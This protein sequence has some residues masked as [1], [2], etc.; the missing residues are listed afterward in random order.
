MLKKMKDDISELDPLFQ[1]G[2]SL[3]WEGDFKSAFKFFDK[4]IKKYG[5]HYLKTFY[6][7]QAVLGQ[8]KLTES[9]SYFNEVL[10]QKQDF[11]EG[12][13]TLASVYRRLRNVVKA[14]EFYGYALKHNPSIDEK[15]EISRSRA[16]LFNELRS[17]NSKIEFLNKFEEGMWYYVNNRLHDAW[18]YFDEYI[19]DNPN[20]HLAYLYSAICHCHC[21]DFKRGLPHIDKY[22]EFKPN[23]AR[24]W[25]VKAHLFER[26][27]ELD[28]AIECCEKAMELDPK[29]EKIK[30]TCFGLYSSLREGH[31][32]TVR[33]EKKSPR[34]ERLTP[35]EVKSPDIR[36]EL[37]SREDESPFPP[38][39]GMALIFHNAKKCVADRDKRVH[40]IAEFLGRFKIDEYIM[41]Q[42]D[43]MS[44]YYLITHQIKP[45]EA[46]NEIV[47]LAAKLIHFTIKD[48]VAFDIYNEALGH[49]KASRFK[50]AIELLNKATELSPYNPMYMLDLY[51]TYQKVGDHKRANELQNKIQ[52]KLRSMES[53]EYAKK[54]FEALKLRFEDKKGEFSNI[55][56]KYNELIDDKKGIIPLLHILTS[57]IVAYSKIEEHR[58]KDRNI[59]T[60][61]DDCL[62]CFE[63]MS[64]IASLVFFHHR[65]QVE[66]KP[67]TIQI[68]DSIIQI[69][70]WE[71]EPLP[72]IQTPN[73][74]S[75]KLRKKAWFNTLGLDV[76]SGRM[77]DSISEARYVHMGGDL[78]N[79]DPNTHMW[80]AK[81]IADQMSIGRQHSIH[82]R[83]EIKKIGEYIEA[84]FGEP[85]TIIHDK[86]GQIVHIDIYVYAPTEERPF[87]MMIT[88]GM[89]ECP[90]NAPPD[91]WK[92]CWP[93]NPNLIPP[94]KREALNCKYA[95]LVVK[96]PP[97]WPLPQPGGQLKN[98]EYLWPIEQLHHLI[99]YVHR[100]HEWF[101]NGHTM[102]GENDN[103]LTFAPNTKLAGW[104]FIYPPNFPPTFGM[105]KI[106]DSKVICFLQ[107]VPAYT[108]EIQ[109]SM[110]YGTKKLIE[111]F[112]KENIPDFIDIK[113]KNICL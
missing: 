36:K 104:V 9:I 42:I 80:Q 84:Q 48:P 94:E 100:E 74:L 40:D 4:S 28:R 111:K 59:T 39:F 112:R 93:I 102:G 49:L 58:L 54:E 46:V 7:G 18:V 23:D 21:R 87:G 8:G 96:L 29:S 105:L 62:Y 68:K 64:L 26:Q 77:M 13:I 67:F 113:R 110:Q 66:D 101:W 1:K 44:L 55:I 20:D 73:F 72:S 60:V 24:G 86:G 31:T 11:V 70:G 90:M 50:K 38:L 107:I 6:K 32:P 43:F 53:K 35:R 76:L 69:L 25:H 41:R 75:P 63:L 108:E 47:D 82:D 14:L 10:N 37:S 95:E 98:D 88:S 30:K 2:Y 56:E 45:Y 78:G 92:V 61:I 106:S 71:P 34:T 51:K 12:F 89:S 27:K 57:E 99:K 22:I 33:R 65:A 103:S 85:F 97:E 109:Y 52:E 15:I 83:A 81:D 17:N 91:A 19:E 16:T 79:D 3:Y 5:E